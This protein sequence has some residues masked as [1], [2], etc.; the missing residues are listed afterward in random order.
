MDVLESV[1]WQRSGR[2]RREPREGHAACND[3]VD[4]TTDASGSLRLWM[5][6]AMRWPRRIFGLVIPC[7][8]AVAFLAGSAL[9]GAFRN[10]L[11]AAI[12]Y[13]TSAAVA[14]ASVRS[15]AGRYHTSAALLLF[16]YLALYYI[17]PVVQSFVPVIDLGAYANAL[18]GYT[19]MT[20]TGVHLFVVAY[21]LAIGASAAPLARYEVARDRLRHVV[22]FFAAVNLAGIALIVWDAGGLHT[23]FAMSRVQRKES[24]TALSAGAGYLLYAGVMLH[25]L[26]PVYLKRRRGFYIAAVAALLGVAF[27]IF[28]VLRTRSVIVGQMIALL[29]GSFVIAPRVTLRPGESVSRMRWSHRVRR[30]IIASLILVVVGGVGMYARHARGL[31]EQYGISGLLRADPEA[32]I[33]A[34]VS[35]GDLGYAPTVLRLIQAVPA[36]HD[37]LRGQSYYRLAFVPIPRRVWKEKPENTQRIVGSWLMPYG[38][39]IQTIPPGMQGDAYINFGLCGVFVFALFGVGF[40]LIDRRSGLGQMLLVGVGFSPLFH[41]ARGGF[42]NP[43]I[44]LAW[45]GLIV[46][47]ASRYLRASRTSEDA[48]LGR[49]RP[50]RFTPDVGL[51]SVP[52]HNPAL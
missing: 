13:I 40:A 28:L 33:T 46:G 36:E 48:A 6:L 25:A 27:L 43:V 20:I 35:H 11:A 44:L 50:I 4:D 42:T 3:P 10:P 34:A 30:V 23:A 26:L 22:L 51:V 47:M 14:V 16:C 38:P 15:I 32:V 18:P 8:A 41:L 5:S 17:Q 45:L 31:F 7:N 19:Y 9:V 2:R 12:L 37:Y 52:F 21:A 24:L 49:I 1:W 39:D 29:M